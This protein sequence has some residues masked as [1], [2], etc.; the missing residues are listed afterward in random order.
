MSK[1]YT[2]VNKYSVSNT[3][4]QIGFAD[5]LFG[6]SGL[7][8]AMKRYNICDMDIICDYS[9]HP[10]N[11]FIYNNLMHSY[12]CNEPV[13]FIT[14]RLIKEIHANIYNE[15]NFLYLLKNK[16]F[17]KLFIKNN[18]IQILSNIGFEAELLPPV[19]SQLKQIISPRKNFLHFLNS[20]REH[21]NLYNYNV[22][23]IRM[24]DESF[25][26][27][28]DKSWGVFKDK[29]LNY[30]F[31]N[32][33]NSYDFSTPLL[34]VS[35]CKGIKEKITNI[36][37]KVIKIN[38]D[39]VHLGVKNNSECDGYYKNVRDTL[40]DFFLIGN[41][42]ETFSIACDRSS[43]SSFCRVA[44]SIFGAKNTQIVCCPSIFYS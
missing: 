17:R 33:L 44:C 43:V 24:G 1:R 2:I 30:L 6:C 8:T 15:N 41:A 10:I 13:H 23:H 34:V 40:I 12:S 18:T 28:K 9:E 25:S 32:F 21:Y 5:Y 26:K 11:M 42:K 35:D 3:P 19:I 39:P 14:N 20:V 29:F 36:Y 37:N 27:I 38:N 7:L 22:L 16:F 31:S 4:F